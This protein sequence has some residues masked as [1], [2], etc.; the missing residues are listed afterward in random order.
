MVSDSLAT[1]TIWALLLYSTG[2]HQSRHVGARPRLD[3]AASAEQAVQVD[4]DSRECGDVE[5]CAE[6]RLIDER[7]RTLLRSAVTDEPPA[8]KVHEPHFRDS[9]KRVERHLRVPVEPQR[10]IGNLDDEQDVGGPRV[11]LAV[12]VFATPQ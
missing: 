7:V 8:T 10:R 12:E 2:R 3:L 9:V 4:S 11:V 6:I 1:A 5:R